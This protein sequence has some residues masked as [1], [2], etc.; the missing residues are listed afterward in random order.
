[1]HMFLLCSQTRLGEDASCGG[2]ERPEGAAG[3][4]REVD[5]AQGPGHLQPHVRHAE[6]AR[7]DGDGAHILRVEDQTQ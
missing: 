6:T 1:M 4:V 2:D 5:R 7:Q 3:D